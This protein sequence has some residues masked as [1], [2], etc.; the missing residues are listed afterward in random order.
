MEWTNP[1]YERD[2]TI[3]QIDF[4]RASITRWEQ[5]I[6]AAMHP[7]VDR[8]ERE[9]T[10]QDC[11]S[12]IEG[13]RHEIMTLSAYLAELEVTLSLPLI[14]PVVQRQASSDD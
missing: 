1:A 8:Y 9:W 13:M 12:N 11:K 10:L 14:K 3:S 4:C 6:Q 2:L 7:S 5:D